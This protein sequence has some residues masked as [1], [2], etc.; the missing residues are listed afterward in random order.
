MDLKEIGWNGM[1]WID[2]AQDRD[3]WRA[4]VNTILN[5]RVPSNSGK[6]LSG[7]IIGGPLRRAQL[8]V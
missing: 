6:F 7:C 5:L 4:L 1:N 3:Q 8:R 2:M